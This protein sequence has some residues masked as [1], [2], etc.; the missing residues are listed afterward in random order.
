MSERVPLRALIRLTIPF[1]VVSFVFVAIYA[2]TQHAPEAHG[3]R[4]AF[5]GSPLARLH[6]QLGMDGVSPGAFDLRAYPNAARARKAILER[7][8]YGAYVQ[9][10]GKTST[11]QTASAAHIA[12]SPTARPI[13]TG[14]GV[15]PRAE[16]MAW[17]R[18]LPSW[19]CCASNWPEAASMTPTKVW[20][21]W[22]PTR[23]SNA[24]AGSAPHTARTI[25]PGS[26]R[27]SA[28]TTA[29]PISGSMKTTATPVIKR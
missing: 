24:A 12:A 8:V 5:V 9:G 27:M 4:I 1:V 15:A 25:A 21:T 29:R 16:G 17:A 19:V 22:I 20:V 10:N 13:I 23:V 28:E 14:T 11:I 26:A 18:A 2:F 7:K 3:L 6:S